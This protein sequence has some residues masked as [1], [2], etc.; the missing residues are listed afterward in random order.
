MCVGSWNLQTAFLESPG[1][2][3]GYF[4]INT[5][6]SRLA[7]CCNV[8]YVTI[9][10]FLYCRYFFFW[11]TLNCYSLNRGSMG[12]DLSTSKVRLRSA[13]TL[14]S[15]DPTLWTTLGM[16]LFVV[17]DCAPAKLVLLI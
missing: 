11:T 13:Y 14:P 15:Q 16:L 10:C 1:N 6:L 2:I 12:N 4:K 3:G 9:C 8:V 17:E 7:H 5:V